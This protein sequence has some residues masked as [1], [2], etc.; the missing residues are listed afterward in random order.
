[1]DYRRLV[2]GDWLLDMGYGRQSRIS[3]P[4]HSTPYTLRFTLQAIATMPLAFNLSPY[5]LIVCQRQCFDA[6]AK[7]MQERYE[8]ARVK[9]SEEFEEHSKIVRRTLKSIWCSSQTKDER[10]RNGQK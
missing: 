7:Q 6:D 2:I 8:V 5:R 10:K 9:T 4:L 1:M 3:V